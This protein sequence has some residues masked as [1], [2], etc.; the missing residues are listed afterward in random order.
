M[1][2]HIIQTKSGDFVRRGEFYD[3]QLVG[4]DFLT[5]AKFTSRNG[6]ISDNQLM[7]FSKIFDNYRLFCERMRT[8]MYQVFRPIFPELQLDGPVTPRQFKGSI[9]P[10]FFHIA[11]N[12]E[13]TVICTPGCLSTNRPIQCT[14]FDGEFF[15]NIMFCPPLSVEFLYGEIKDI[16]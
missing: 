1:I 6:K 11:S 2:Q 9:V 7:I 15:E 8:A 4:S 16:E 13:V 10:Y 5:G 3:A 14:T 12:G